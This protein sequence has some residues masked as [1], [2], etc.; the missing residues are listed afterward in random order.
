MSDVA[1]IH[2]RLAAIETTQKHQGDIL[3]KIDSK[4]DR[5]GERIGAVEMKAATFGTVAGGIIS[6]AVALVA[7]KLKGGA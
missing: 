2:E 7:S 1:A 6:V 4:M 3:T 5:F